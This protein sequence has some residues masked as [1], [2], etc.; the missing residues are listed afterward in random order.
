MKCR[1]PKYFL[2]IQIIALYFLVFGV[3]GLNAQVPLFEK[4]YPSPGVDVCFSVRQLPDSSV[5][6]F[7]YSDNGT[8]GGYDFKLMKLTPDG[9]HCWTKF[10]GTTALDFGLFMNRADSFNLILIGTTQNSSPFFGDDVLLIKVD[11]SGNEMWR[12]TIGSFGNESCR[13]V[14][15]TKDGGYIMC[16]VSPDAGGQ[17]D[18]WVVKTDSMGNVV[19]TNSFGG[20]D[21]DVAARVVAT[22]DTTWAM[23]CDTRFGG[24]GSY[25]V[26]VIGLDAGGNQAFNHIHLDPLTNGCQGM[27]FTSGQRIISFGETEIFPN[28]YFDFLVHFFDVNGNPV[29]DFHFGGPGAEAMFDMIEIPGGDLLGTGYTNSSSNAQL[30]IN[31]ALLRVDTLGNLVWMREFGGNSI[32]L[33][34]SLIP[35]LGGGYYVAGRTTRADE[36][37]YLIHFDENGQTG[38]PPPPGG[39]DAQLEIWPNPAGSQVFFKTDLLQARALLLQAD[40]RVVRTLAATDNSFDVSALASGLY[41][42][43][44]TDGQYTVSRKFQ[45]LH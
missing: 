30:P 10:Y 18:A 22:S 31:L 44:L 33:G 41:W 7:G 17:N 36:D 32:D 9:T 34:Y 45:V 2:H 1:S 19:W 28:S 21:N 8:A 14:E 42:L 12:Q 16:G 5:Y 38:L 4:Y 20:P 26:Q 25:D 37:F 11:S 15:Q 35:A 39:Q 24:T 13:Y 6:L 29:R 27:L 43:V 40:G 3:P 23:T